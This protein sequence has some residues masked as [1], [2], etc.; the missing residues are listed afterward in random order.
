LRRLRPAPLPGVGHVVLDAAGRRRL[1]TRSQGDGGHV[2][3]RIDVSVGNGS[4]SAAAAEEATH[5]I[6][7]FLVPDLSMIAFAS[8][9]EALRLANRMSGRR[10]YSWTC[11]SADGGPVVASNGVPI[12]VEGSFAEARSLP[13]VIVCSG[14]DVQRHVDK[15]LLSKLRWLACHGAG[16]GAVCT[17]TY[18]LAKAGLLDGYRCTIHWEN[19]SGFAE[20]FP[21]ID[22]TAELFEFDRN[23]FT[24][25]G[26]TAALDMMLHM[27][28]IQAGYD[29]AALVA[30]VMIHH[31]IRDGDE[32][33]RMELRSR[34]G[35]SHP[36]LLA[37]ISHM[38][39]SLEE[40]KSC[41]DLA[42]NVG[43]STRQLERLFRKYLN[44][45][46]T[47]YYL[48][49]RLNRARFLLL[50]T[51]MPIL[52]V[53]LACGF[54]SA[55]HFSKTY[56]EFFGRTPS[57]ERRAFLIAANTDRLIQDMPTVRA[58]RG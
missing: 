14:V 15:A 55:S 41:K 5:R 18:V 50:Q 57:Q 1:N 49:L 19:L 6:G 17:G 9:V 47:R 2:L 36:K 23:R 31:R 45:A 28:A 37:V 52:D 20:Q 25:A 46:P 40:P 32:R 27:I 3:G 13:M 30:D 26:G 12:G 16:I 24:C 38:E 42:R 44:D 29:L 48:G 4:D 22:I 56:R 10:L 11:H 35:V 54:V 21:E 58:S 53:A 39:D 34:L 43:L 33:Q 7:F 51:S 8:A